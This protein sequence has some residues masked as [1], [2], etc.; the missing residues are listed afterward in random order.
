MT[1]TLTIIAAILFFYVIPLIAKPE[2]LF[3]F[4]I[5]FLMIACVTLLYTQP[6]LSLK[7]AGETR[8]TDKNSVFAILISTSMAQLTAVTEW[9]YFREQSEHIIPTAIGISML[10]SGSLF[11]IWS[12]QTLGRFFTAT[13]QI[14]EK[15]RIITRGPYSIVRHPSYLGA[16]IAIVGGAIFLQSVFGFIVAMVAMAV[17]YKLRITAEEE[18]LTKAFGKDYLA[19]KT[20]T[21]KMIPFVW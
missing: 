6:P 5:L 4:K 11:R 17:A 9:A 19:Y 15:H 3:H 12:I 13:V 8:D 1:K 10:V 14:K 21:S 20:Q 18:T 16:Y 7:E 2:L